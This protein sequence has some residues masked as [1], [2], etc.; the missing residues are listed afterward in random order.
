M[1][2]AD[3]RGEGTLSP[4]E[5]EM[6]NAYGPYH[7]AVWS[8]GGV[9]ISHEERLSGRGE[10][11]VD[12][13]RESLLKRFTLDE[14][15][16]FSILDVG[17][18]DGWILQQLSELPFARLVGIEPRE[19]NLMKGQKVRELL[20]IPSRVEF[21]VG[22]LDSLG[23]ETFDVV[24][25]AGLLHHVE[26]TPAAL[27]RLRAVCRRFLFIETIC[28]SSRHITK[29]LQREIEMK[30]VV[31]FYKRKICGVTGQKWESSY[32]DGSTT[33]LCV[34]NIPSL[35]S[36][37]M[38]LDLSEYRAAVW[39]DQR[40][41]NAVC[42]SAVI[43]AEQPEAVSEEES[44]VQGYERGLARTILKKAYVQPLYEI[45]CLRK[46]RV[47]LP[48]SCWTTWLYLRSP[49]RW[50]GLCH[51]LTAI[52]FKDRYALEIV[53]NLR[54]NPEDKLRLEYG[55]VL[56]DEGDTEGAIA[57]LK[58]VVQT[59]NADW[60]SVYR[61]FA[62]L[63]DAY[64]RIGSHEEAQR[65][66]SLCATCNPKFP[67]IAQAARGFPESDRQDHDD[68]A[69]SMIPRPASVPPTAGPC[70]PTAHQPILQTHAACGSGKRGV[71]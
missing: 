51:S 61:S 53:K 31:Y 16:T 45:W 47:R 37:T 34:V 64:V 49:N 52:W 21:K 23:E 56:C 65:Y 70:L 13:I 9:A 54:F 10:F 33:R 30:D 12:R 17:C 41:C 29:A 2:R 50:A 11:L 63:S 27:R 24:I 1:E 20:R 4:R 67:H 55:K 62:L 3:H 28:L 48:V 5:V 43:R 26:S 15:K 39:R 18:Y 8:A 36:L 35:E 68:G 6:V 66:A 57:V 46:K 25:C 44:W 32:S 14:I 60:W 69:M 22:D 42:L 38:Y 59:L 58:A 7:H 19:K 40:A 71:G